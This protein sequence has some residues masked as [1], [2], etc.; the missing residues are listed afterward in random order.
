MAHSMITDD[1]QKTEE[2][3]AATKHSAEIIDKVN[4]LALTIDKA[5]LEAFLVVY[6]SKEALSTRAISTRVYSAAIMRGLYLM[7]TDAQKLFEVENGSNENDDVDATSI[8][9]LLNEST[10]IKQMLMTN[11]KNRVSEKQQQRLN[12]LF[13]DYLFSMAVD[14]AF[15]INKMLR[16][17]NTD[18]IFSELFA[19]LQKAISDVNHILYLKYNI[20]QATASDSYK[21]KLVS[22]FNDLYNLRTPYDK[23]INNALYKLYIGY[24]ALRPA[25]T[26]KKG[27]SR[28]RT[29]WSQSPPFAQAWLMRR[30]E[31]M[32]FFDLKL[33][34]IGH[35]KITKENMQKAYKETI[36]NYYDNNKYL[37][38]FAVPIAL[39]K[40]YTLFT[41]S[42]DP[43]DYYCDLTFSEIFKDFFPKF[44]GFL[45]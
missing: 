5:S 44:Q 7:G 23:T 16:S 41:Y 18:K 4:S 20:P 1:K 31:I 27:K 22:L 3:E 37:E 13:D 30:N 40:K 6:L 28:S 10:K 24:D 26:D 14:F 17:K 36:L 34:E 33:K 45:P 43:N 35:G 21:V 29:Y 38:F 32:N 2:I 19:N 42:I 9:R 12:L 39:A 25:D 8:I 11:Y 15:P